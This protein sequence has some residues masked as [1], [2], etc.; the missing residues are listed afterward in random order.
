MAAGFLVSAVESAL[1]RG[2]ALVVR[3]S[4]RRIRWWLAEKQAV[5]PG[6]DRIRMRDS[7]NVLWPLA[8]TGIERQREAV[9]TYEAA[10]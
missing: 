6:A 8:R 3:S 9:K 5:E 2:F 10:G 7:T 1:R 4:N